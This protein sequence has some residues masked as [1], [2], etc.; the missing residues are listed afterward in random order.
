M[1]PPDGQ[2]VYQCACPS[3]ELSAGEYACLVTFHTATTMDVVTLSG[4]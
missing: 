3:A 1:A 2:S 4:D